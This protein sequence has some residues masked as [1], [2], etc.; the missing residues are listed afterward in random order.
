MEHAEVLIV[1]AG[2]SG[3]VAAG[4]LAEA[5]FDVLCLKQGDRPDRGG[6]PA[7][8]ATYEL[9]A[10]RR[11]TGNPNIQLGRVH[12]VAVGDRSGRTRGVS[13]LTMTPRPRRSPKPTMSRVGYVR[14]SSA[15][16][17]RRVPALRTGAADGL[18]PAAPA[19]HSARTASASMTSCTLSATTTP[20]PSMA[21]FQLTPNSLRLISPVALKP[22]RVPP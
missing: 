2:A 22:A 17:A 8:R 10:R 11:W 7:P 14:P 4:A 12:L 5:G 3:G 6:F 20:P 9:E 13:V 15:A 19:G 16:D 1:G 18:G 21:A